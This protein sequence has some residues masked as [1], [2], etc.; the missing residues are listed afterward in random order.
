MKDCCLVTCSPFLYTHPGMVMP[1]I[2]WFPSNRSLI[3]KMSDRCAYRPY[4]D[5]QLLLLLSR[6]LLLVSRQ[7]KAHQHSCRGEICDRWNQ[8]HH[9]NRLCEPKELGSN[10]S[11]W[12]R[13]YHS[14]PFAVNIRELLLISWPLYI[15]GSQS[16][17]QN[18]FGGCLIS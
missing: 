1:T 10:F 5:I 18:L 14:C 8:I 13:E 15:S 17:F 7:Y 11:E 2:G 9:S 12:L 3:K 6:W 4:W 16:L